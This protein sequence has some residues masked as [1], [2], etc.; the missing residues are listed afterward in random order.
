MC[1]LLT[2]VKNR[3]AS[4]GLGEFINERGNISSRGGFPNFEHQNRGFLFS[5]EK[6]N[7]ALSINLAFANRR[8]RILPLLGERVGVRASLYSTN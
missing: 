1:C 6:E 4:P 5:S 7:A 2:D 3:G 8:P